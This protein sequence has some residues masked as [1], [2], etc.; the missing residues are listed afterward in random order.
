MNAHDLSTEH[1]AIIQQLWD[2]EDTNSYDST[3]LCQLAIQV[4]KQLSTLLLKAI[5]LV[6]SELIGKIQKDVGY[7]WFCAF[8][9][10]N[11]PHTAIVL[12]EYARKAIDSTTMAVSFSQSAGDIVTEAK[13]HFL[14]AEI[15]RTL[16]VPDTQDM[17]AM[18]IALNEGESQQQLQQALQHHKKAIALF[19][20]ALPDTQQALESAE[21]SFSQLQ[22]LITLAKQMEGVLDNIKNIEA[23]ISVDDAVDNTEKIDT[24]PLSSVEHQQKIAQ[25]AGAGIDTSDLFKM[26]QKQF[27]IEA[28]EGN[29]TSERHTMLASMMSELGQIV[30]S[31]PD[32][33]TEMLANSSR[34][35]DL[36]ERMID[37]RETP[38]FR[39]DAPDVDPNSY[40]AELLSNYNKI[41]RYLDQVVKQPHH[42][43]Y[44][45]EVLQ[46]LILRGINARKDIMESTDDDAARAVEKEVIRRLAMDVRNFAMREHLTFAC[47]IWPSPA[48]TENPNALFYSGSDEIRQQLQLAIDEYSM[49]LSI[50]PQKTQGD[51]ARARWNQL[52]SSTLCVFD[53]AEYERPHSKDENR[54]QKLAP[55]A[56]A[57]YELGMAFALGRSVLVIGRSTKPL[58]FDIDV[59][60]VL[61]ENSSFDDARLNIGIN[62]ALY[63]A[64]QR[65][66]GD[67]SVDE[68]LRFALAEYA[69]HPNSYVRIAIQQIE[70]ED[71]T[72]ALK[73]AD[74]LE[75][76]LGFMGVEAP[77][78]ITPAWPGDY[79]SN[80]RCFHVTAFG[81]D[82]ADQV[83]DLVA[84]CCYSSQEAIEYIRGDEVLTPDIIRS[85]WDEICRASHIV[86]DLTGLNVNAMLEL[87]MAHV[88]GR[89]VII[90]S[91]DNDFSHYPINI[92]KIRFH[93]YTLDDNGVQLLNRTLNKFLVS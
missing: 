41:Q 61:L 52:R 33:L 70:N 87:A 17:Q 14:L 45:H 69:K 38:S 71:E 4:T 55:F 46:N 89:K 86:V 79:P 82:W 1:Q 40:A 13:A 42:K 93:Q 12:D 3:S 67:S 9:N 65:G 8:R 2:A 39:P 75:A 53:F 24:Q 23:K 34:L 21:T 31:K 6:D 27:Q 84:E 37:P 54:L 58:P 85:I 22:Q 63:G 77:L 57:A 32:D 48:I 64:A 90:I 30:D 62:T 20:S 73:I 50:Q 11:I 66:G 72:D 51:P 56:T 29:F 7:S 36:Q 19:Q 49:N 81:Y 43:K 83:R 88:L 25:A 60:P 26:L 76:G 44:T 28:D 74:M 5:E 16:A 10:Q 78:L 47:P 18:T 91:Q 35:R 80:R 68:T 59:T 15:K 92:K